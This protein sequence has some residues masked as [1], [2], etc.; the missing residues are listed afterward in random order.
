[1]GNRHAVRGDKS[2]FGWGFWDSKAL[3]PVDRK[4]VSIQD[5]FRKKL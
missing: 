3:G 2:F 4:F 5:F 1:M